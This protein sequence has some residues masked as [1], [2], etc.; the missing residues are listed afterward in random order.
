MSQLKLR[1]AYG[2][3]GNFAPFGAIYT[4]LVPAIFN[5]TTGSLIGVTR[6]NSRLE[7]ERQ[8][9]LEL[10]IDF[11][12]LNNRITFEG[13]YYIKKTDN[14]I[15]KI[16]IPR[17]SGFTDSWKNAAAIRNRGIELQMNAIP[18]AG[19]ACIQGLPAPPIVRPRQNQIC[20]RPRSLA[21]WP[22]AVFPAGVV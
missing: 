18:V 22:R 1:A 8:K 21:R 2:E 14:L 10:G 5:G 3:S 16:E 19:K 13:T 9:E 17:S 6:G 7:P 11:G 4:P 15:L 12:I 20:Y